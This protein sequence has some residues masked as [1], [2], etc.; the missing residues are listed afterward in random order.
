M[1]ECMYC[2]FVGTLIS[3]LPARRV[4]N[5]LSLSKIPVSSIVYPQGRRNEK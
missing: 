2:L 5:R 3:V 1:I 4:L